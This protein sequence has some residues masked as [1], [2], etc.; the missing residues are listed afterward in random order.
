MAA[1][2]EIVPGDPDS[3]VLLH[4]PH[5]S[6]AIPPDVRAG[7]VLSDVQLDAELTAI[8]DADTD[9]LALRAA[10]LARPR[11]WVFVNR[12]SRLVVDPERF[13]DETE[14]M[15]AVGMGVVYE[16]TTQ[17]DVL[18]RPSPREHSSL[19]ERFFVP[20]AAALAQFVTDRLAATGGVTVVDVHS[21]PKTAL[22]Y[23][24][25]GDGPRPEICLGTD[26]FHTSPALL[27]AAREALGPAAPTG[28][29]GVDSPF[30][31]CYVPLERYRTDTRVE[32]IMLEIRRDVLAARPSPLATAMSSLIEAVSSPTR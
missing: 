8:T 12:L 17:R 27:A 10:D 15:N 26:G 7:I 16:A 5:A 23:E 25:H 20:Y 13:P 14:E 11:P 1:G 9:A 19:V 30:S 31:G 3:T 28:E 29:I 18:R 32:A 6:R 2:F 22:P 21:Y 24:L 4:V